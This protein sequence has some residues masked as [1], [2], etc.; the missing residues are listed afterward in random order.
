MVDEEIDLANPEELGF[1]TTHRDCRSAFATQSL[2]DF[3]IFRR[4]EKDKKVSRC[5]EL[6]YLQMATEKMAK[7]LSTP[8]G[9]MKMPEKVHSGLRG[10]LRFAKGRKRLQTICGFKRK[11]DYWGYL[12]SITPIAKLVEELAPA[13]D[14]PSVNPEYPWLARIAD[15]NNRGDFVEIIQVPSEYSFPTFDYLRDPRFEKFFS[16]LRSCMKYLEEEATKGDVHS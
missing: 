13:I 12:D 10:F 11:T 4:F 15:P 14:P 5:H 7:S 9:S 16:F 3:E 6:H 2:S 1:M 8:Q